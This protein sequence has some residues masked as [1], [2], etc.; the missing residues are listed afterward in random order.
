MRM[1]EIPADEERDEKRR[2]KEPKGLAGVRKTHAA[3]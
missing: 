1:S 2:E 3:T